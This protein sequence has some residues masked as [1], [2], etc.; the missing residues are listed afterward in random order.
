MPR[1][2]GTGPMGNG[3]RTG[4]GM[5]F[6]GAGRMSNFFCRGCRFQ[7]AYSI[8]D[9]LAELKSQEI[10]LEKELVIIRERI[11]HFEK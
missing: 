1:F 6:C 9:E 5:G 2:D 10:A 3:P 7:Q 4:R 11:A 8:E